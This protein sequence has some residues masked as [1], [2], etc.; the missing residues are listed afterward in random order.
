MGFLFDITIGHFAVGQLV[1]VDRLGCIHNLK[2]FP[3]LVTKT[4]HEILNRAV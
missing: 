4:V 2:F 1:K 3:C